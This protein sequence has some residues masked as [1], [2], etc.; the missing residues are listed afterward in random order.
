M[1]KN[2]IGIIF[3]TSSNKPKRTLIY[4]VKV[5]GPGHPERAKLRKK[6]NSD[7]EW[8]CVIEE[9]LYVPEG[10]PS[11]KPGRKITKIESSIYKDGHRIIKK[12]FFVIG[13]S[14]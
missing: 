12:I 9:S 14:K 1:L 2:N 6:F 3:S 7:K 13:R 4:L 11:K 8:E 10:Y 5:I